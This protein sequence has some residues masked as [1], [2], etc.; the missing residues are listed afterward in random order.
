VPLES[1][2]TARSRSDQRPDLFT[3]KSL[4]PDVAEVIQP[5]VIV[6]RRPG[7]TKIEITTA[8][9]TASIDVVVA[10]SG[11]DWVL[12]GS[13]ADDDVASPARNHRRA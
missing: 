12:S 9:A 13:E 8:S 5:G 6:M 10:A 4:D 11:V 2:E 7:S 3:W 1:Q